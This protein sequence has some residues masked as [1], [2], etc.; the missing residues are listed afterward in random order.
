[1]LNPGRYKEIDYAGLLGSF[2]ASWILH[3]I[4]FVIATTTTIFYPP[5]ANR[6]YISI[7]LLFASPGSGSPEVPLAETSQSSPPHNADENDGVDIEAD[8]PIPLK[9][10]QTESSD[11]LELLPV[12]APKVVTKKIPTV[13][14]TPP[15]VS[16]PKSQE[17]GKPPPAPVIVPASVDTDPEETTKP[18]AVE[19]A[20][21]PPAMEVK[22]KSLA[23][24][25]Q[26]K[27]AIETE[28]IRRQQDAEQKAAQERVLEETRAAEIA[29]TAELEKLAA[30]KAARLKLTA[31]NERIQ[32]QREAELNAAK[33]AQAE[34]TRIAELEKQAAEK[35]ARARLAA[36]KAQ[37]EREAAEKARR[38]QLV[39]L[40]TEEE[41][42]AREKLA[43]EHAAAEKAA[44]DKLEQTRLAAIPQRNINTLP[45]K[46]VGSPLSNGAANAAGTV[47]A[48]AT[49]TEKPLTN[50]APPI[51]TP[52]TQNQPEL[53]GLAL[54]PVNGDIKLIM[55]SEK[56]LIV[57]V[58]FVSYPKVR[59]D[60]PMSK[61]EA[62]EQQKLTPV[63]VRTAK[64]TL[65]AVI[66]RSR[67]GIYIFLV[68]PEGSEPVQGRF[69]LKLFETKTKTVTGRQISGQ[70]E[71]VRLLMPEGILWEDDSAFSGNIEDSD[72]ITKFNSESGLV[73][74]EYRR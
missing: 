29:K 21:P 2:I 31:E 19:A 74:K 62:K 12:P 4:L 18:T 55:T 45:A 41:K 39:R 42:A 28:K 63:V 27:L 60:K 9:T 26:E 20:A 59:H 30:E 71:V 6:E 47:I 57:K 1:M 52:Q 3:C 66:E 61:K 69:L 50:I 34:L 5:T 53:K 49:A 38:E 73:W 25:E 24:S 16:R 35:A 40:K 37:K 70:T 13:K 51:G 56:D 58:L 65:E 48:T 67:E 7:D 72:S 33:E 36:A 14:N 64:N 23:Q 17:V 8:E 54:P 43:R 22:A 15:P 11:E 46:P 10:A 32:R 44:K 68:E